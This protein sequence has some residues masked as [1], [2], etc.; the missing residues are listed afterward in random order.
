M[1]NSVKFMQRMTL[2]LSEQDTSV[3][4]STNTYCIPPTCKIVRKL[5]HVLKSSIFRT[6]TSSL[7]F[8]PFTDAS[9]INDSLLQQML[10]V[11]HPLLQFV[12]ITDPLLRTAELF[13]RFYSHIIVYNNNNNNNEIA[14]V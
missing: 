10:H 4:N 9:V 13:S 5:K 6:N 12:Y 8:T 7:T 1:I 3:C 14:F 11:H 2:A